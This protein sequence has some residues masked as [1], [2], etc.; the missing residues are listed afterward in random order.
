MPSRNGLP[1]EVG[2]AVADY[3]IHARPADAM[4]REVFCSARAPRRPLTCGAVSA[5]VN[6]ASERAGLQ[7]FYAHRLRHTL[8]EASLL[9]WYRDGVDVAA[10]MPV[11]ST[12]L[13]HT[14]PANTYWYLSAVPELMAHAATRLAAVEGRME[15]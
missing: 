6:R 12:Y 10:R 4:H 3:L 13:G 5:I 14:S 9:G 7:P 8:G 11:L 15:P 2:Q 1:V